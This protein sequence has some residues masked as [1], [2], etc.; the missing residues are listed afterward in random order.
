MNFR[1]SDPSFLEL[2]Q[3]K[4]IDQPIVLELDQTKRNYLHAAE[5]S[6]ASVIGAG[7][8]TKVKG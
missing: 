2:I 5:G 8:F 4:T 7:L 6:D 3:T 1:D